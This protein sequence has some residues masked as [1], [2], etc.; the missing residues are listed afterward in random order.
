[1]ALFQSPRTPAHR[2]IPLLAALPTLGSVPGAQPALAWPGQQNLS[3][4]LPPGWLEIRSLGEPFLPASEL[5]ML[6]HCLHQGSLATG[7]IS[8]YKYIL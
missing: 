1:M 7:A 6:P 8:T 5:T 2:S 4:L 3:M